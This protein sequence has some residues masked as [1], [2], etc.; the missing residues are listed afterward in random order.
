MTVNVQFPQDIMKHSPRAVNNYLSTFTRCVYLKRKKMQVG[1]IAFLLR[2]GKALVQQYLD[3]IAECE[4][5][6]NMA[7]HLEELLRLGTCPNG[8]KK[9][10]RRRHNA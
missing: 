1:Q 6:K 8:G 9:S 10:G 3:I 4:S 7:Y 5:D 2:R